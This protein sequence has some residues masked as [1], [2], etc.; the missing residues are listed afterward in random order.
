MDERRLEVKVGVLVL[1]G[2]AG[3]L[4]L[5]W[6][7]GE[8]AFSRDPNLG[9]L[10]SHTGNVVVG[11]PVKLGGVD[12]G[13]V[14]QIHL[15]PTRRDDS[16]DPLPVRIDVF[17]D[18]P[19]FS[20][21]HTDAAVTVATMGPLGESY[22]ELWPGSAKAPPLPKNAVLR[23]T[24]P[25]RLDLVAL[26]LSKFLDSASAVLEQNPEALNTIVSGVS[27]LGESVGNVGTLLNE[28]RDEVRTLA[29]ELAQAAKDLRA[30]SGL[31][32]RNLEPGGRGDRILD[33]SAATLKSLRT[34][35]P[36]LSED[37][38]QVLGKLAT[39]SQSFDE[40]DARKLKVA[41]DRYSAAGEKLDSL[42]SRGDRLLAQIE[43]GEGTLG[44]I[45]KDTELY[46]DLKALVEDLRKHPWKI[47]WKD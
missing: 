1:T 41:I 30:L 22:L 29:V 17:V 44:Q 37:A 33:D 39:M 2:V 10:F 9:L 47:L 13:R 28:N 40:E 20:A 21:L 27:Q 18:D 45:Q 16:G 7:M 23:G 31:A 46:R 15:D 35:V 3:V 42:A 24:D 12:V 6:L 38:R 26:Q 4:A 14:E 32:R 34:N 5:L 25:P 36:V 8:L 19:T 11:A 43:A